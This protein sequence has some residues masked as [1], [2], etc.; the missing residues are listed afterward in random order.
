MLS[1]ITIPTLGSK[2]YWLARFREVAALCQNHPPV[3]AL[4]LVGA[5]ESA[6]VE[7]VAEGDRLETVNGKGNAVPPLLPES[8]QD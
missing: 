8:S 5:A 7:A 6:G 3:P 2:G 4:L 1:G